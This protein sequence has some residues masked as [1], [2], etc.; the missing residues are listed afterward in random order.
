MKKLVLAVIFA[1]V[2]VVLGMGLAHGGKRNAVVTSAPL[3][4][5]E[6]GAK[7]LCF[8]SHGAPEGKLRCAALDANTV[9]CVGN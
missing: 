3:S 8:D 2:A 1:T 7:T 6:Q 9:Y 5:Y 4:C